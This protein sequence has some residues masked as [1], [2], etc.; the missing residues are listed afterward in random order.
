[1]GLFMEPIKKALPSFDAVFGNAYSLF[2]FDLSM[3]IPGAIFATI[4]SV[5]TLLVAMVLA[6]ALIW[7][8][9]R[10]GGFR[11]QKSSL[12]DGA[13]A[14]LLKDDVWEARNAHS[15]LIAEHH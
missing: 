1:M 11:R 13:E 6:T 12:Q 8:A 3:T 10:G 2:S 14:V 7:F 9:V 15:F 4:T 5:G